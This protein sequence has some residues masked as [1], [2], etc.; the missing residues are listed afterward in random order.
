M[1]NATINRIIAA[2]VFVLTFAVY[3]I[4]LAPTVVF[5]DVG[6]F[7][8]AAKMM[9]VPHPPGSPLFLLVTRVAM[10]IPVAA[11]MAVRAHMLSALFSAIAIVFLYLIAVRVIVSFRGRPESLLD[12][13]TVYGA[14][15]IGALALA[16]ST[17][18]WANSIEAEVYGASM[19]FLSAIL[20]LATR[21]LDHS[22]VP[23]NEKYML[24]I[25]YLIGLS[26]GVH[27]LA[28]L[29]IFPVLMIVYFKKYEFTLASFVKFWLIA[30]AVFFVVYPGIVKFLPGMMDGDFMGRRS[31]LIAYVPWVIIAAVC[32]GVYTSYKKKQKLLHFSLLAML[33]IL[34]GY[35][36]Y[37]QVIIRS[38][39]NPPMNEND[40]SNLARLTAYLGREQ[41]GDAPLFMPRRYSQ[42]PHQQ[43]I[44]TNYSSEW[45]FLFR[46]QLNHMFVRYLSWN[47]IGAAGDEQDSGVDWNVTFGIPFFLGLFGLYSHFKRDWKMGLVLL[48]TFIIL[49]PVLALYQN[50][51]EPQPRERD[52]FY[53]GAFFIFALWISI[54]VV[55]LI[56]WLRT[57]TQ[58]A[59]LRNAATYGVVG[60][61]TLIVP[62]RLLQ[63]NWE[64]H[65][66]SGNY[67]AWDYSYNMLQ[68]CEKD[69]IL[70]TNGDNDTFP[71][72]YLQDV[73][74]VRRD[75]RIVNLSLV[76]T[77]WYIRQ[78]KGPAYYKEAIPVPISLS[79]KQIENIQPVVWETRQLDIPVPADALARY[80]VTDTAIAHAGKISFVMRHTLEVS[81]TRAIRI[82][83]ILVRDIIFANQWKRPV[84]FAVTCAPDSKIG[85]DEYL[86]FHGLAWRLE[87]RK[88]GRE[89]MGLN[90]DVLEQNLYN[91][92]Q[93]FSTGPQYGYKFRGIA[94]PD[95]YFDENTSRLMLNYR[96]AF[97][98]L[99]MYYMNVEP[100][101]QKGIAALERMEQ[102]IPQKKIPMGWELMSDLSNIYHRLGKEDKFNQLANELETVSRELIA[103]GQANLNSYYNPYRVL[104]DIYDIR[105]ENRKSLELLQSLQ[106]QFPNDPNLNQR[107]EFLKTQIA[108]EESARK[109][110]ARRP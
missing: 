49:G 74:G 97:I 103:S 48:V 109:D 33:L 66:R 70:F 77:S 13:V 95:V 80:N 9:Q 59:S 84:Y 71:L 105:K 87:P 45:D 98:R 101:P 21:W 110:T 88:V 51:Q 57:L 79:D 1:T 50:Q 92:P 67:V 72:W 41:Y 42:E 96:S 32:Y 82:Q 65:D 27:L 102:L 10:M 23:G 107:V 35:T 12:R 106:T 25:A 81:G 55:A 69:A 6:E 11:D 20:W 16:F 24:L 22:D 58:N 36:T 3:L 54:G 31:N 5:W 28:L 17:S 38:N 78:M 62:G 53:V 91:E 89:D 68:S 60:V 40:P 86:W 99:A 93:T 56:D 39:A 4:T 15:A 75:V 52:Y 14:A 61:C 100:N 90:K 30:V 29:A 43:G 63:V 64:D 94:D 7:I 85:L 47:F 83:D 104:L 8:A 19:F 44:Y 18:Y 26:L 73:E 37:V 2:L 46:Y 108:L 34:I 76:N